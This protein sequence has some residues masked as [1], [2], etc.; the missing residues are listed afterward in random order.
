VAASELLPVRG[1]HPRQGAAGAL[2]D[3]AKTTQIA[4]PWARANDPPKAAPPAADLQTG[5]NARGGTRF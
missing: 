1:L 4:V 3:R 5:E 2:R